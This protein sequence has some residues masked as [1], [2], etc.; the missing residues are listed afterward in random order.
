M[1]VKAERRSK[2][3]RYEM[4]RYPTVMC[5]GENIMRKS[6]STFRLSLHQEFLSLFG[7]KHGLSIYLPQQAN[8]TYSGAMRV[9]ALKREGGQCWCGGISTV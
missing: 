9:G 3:V 2:M 1:V 5:D 6:F 4:C 8:S 7:V